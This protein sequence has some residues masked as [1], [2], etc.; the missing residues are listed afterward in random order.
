MTP[1]L[2]II[3]TA[4]AL[5]GDIGVALTVNGRGVETTSDAVAA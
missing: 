3:Y 5:R 2:R 4:E 1:D